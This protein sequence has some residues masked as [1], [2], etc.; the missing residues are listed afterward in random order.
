MNGRRATLDQAYSAISD[1]YRGSD[2]DLHAICRELRHASPIMEGDLL[3]R[4]GIPTNAKHDADRPTFTLFKHGH[5][6]DVLRDATNFTSGFIAEGLGA[7][8]DGLIII[9]MDGEQHRK[10]R[11]LLQ[12]AFMPQA[13]NPWRG[14]L[15][16][17]A[18]DEFLVP[19][20]RYG[21]ADLM[22]FGLNFPIRAIY[23]I[24]GFPEDDPDAIRQYAARAL[25][26]LAG[27]QADP[28]RAEAS[29]TAAITAARA[30][31]DV[32]LKIV[33][34]RRA[35]GCE[36]D[37]V[38][39]RLLRAEFEERRLDDH[40]I[41]TFVRSLLPAAGET[42]TRTFSCIMTLLLER[43]E[44]VA[45][46]R[47]DRSLIAKLIDETIRYEPVST[48]KVRQAAKDLE[49]GGVAIPKG[50]MVQCIVASANRDEEVFEDPDRF[51]IDR[52]QKPSF[53]FGYGVHMCI[54]HYVA[55]AELTA[56]L[57]A[58]LDLLPDLRLDPD[59][60]PPVITGAMLRGAS[61]LHVRWG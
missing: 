19:I 16:R 35:A 3:A 5:V 54:G 37:D 33:Q 12:P 51:D 11:G 20:V 25:D 18:R 29:R 61:S 50:A 43:P 53:G 2:V 58:I 49:I 57:N 27:P 44:L 7:F 42:T 32:T 48:A 24:I 40:E 36:G 31:Y 8:F 41:S 10:A 46:V 21:R 17:I 6:A 38:I 1:N 47:E 14:K 39:G 59:Y 26:I 4:L 15:D 23:S 13:V 55:K 9:A 28:A 22:S 34:E 45:R 56:A 52:R 60:P 30:L